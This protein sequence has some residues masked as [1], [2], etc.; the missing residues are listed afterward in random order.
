MTPHD[1]IL[2][3][4][5]P[6]DGLEDCQAVVNIN[7]YVRHHT[8][9]RS[10]VEAL[11]SQFDGVVHIDQTTALRPLEITA[12]WAVPEVPETFPSGV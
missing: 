3:T 7:R 11:S 9:G 12:D 2:T 8:R 10:A 1:A 6:L 4:L 5:T